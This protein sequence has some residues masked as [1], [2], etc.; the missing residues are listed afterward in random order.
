[1]GRRADAVNTPS[2]A[3]HGKPQSQLENRKAL[4][5]DI[6]VAA[7]KHWRDKWGN[8]LFY[9]GGTALIL[10]ATALAALLPTVAPTT[11]ILGIDGTSLAQ[12]LSALA[13]LLVAAQRIYGP[14]KRF[15]HHEGLMNDYKAL[16]SKTYENVDTA[17]IGEEYRSLLKKEQEPI[18]D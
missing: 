17:T 11:P 3:A 8:S 7:N 16:L 14:V 6:E 2:G 12:L 10:I 18:Q 1:M 15:K 5:R 13:G 9:N 4:T